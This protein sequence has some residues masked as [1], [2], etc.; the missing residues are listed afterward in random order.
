MHNLSLYIRSQFQVP[1]SKCWILYTEFEHRAEC[2]ANDQLLSANDRQTDRQTDRKTEG[3]QQIREY[4]SL[5]KKVKV[6]GNV[7]LVLNKVPRHEDVGGME[8]Q[9]HAFLISTVDGGEWLASRPYRF[10][11][12]ERASGTHSTEGWGGP[13]AGLYTTM[14]KEKE[15]LPLPGIEL[16]LSSQ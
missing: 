9:H 1:M 3:D 16:R 15:P 5:L 10:T 4:E 8:V 12:A 2:M 6:W 14:T 11:P 13:R 7:V